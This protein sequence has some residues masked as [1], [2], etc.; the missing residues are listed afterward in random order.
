MAKN[1]A[2]SPAEI[3]KWADA[4]TVYDGK[5]TGSFWKFIGTIILEVIL[6]LAFAAAGVVLACWNIVGK[7]GAWYEDIKNP[8]TIACIIGGGILVLIGVYVVMAINRKHFLNN[9]GKK[10]Q[11]WKGYVDGKFVIDTRVVEKAKAAKNVVDSYESKAG[12]IFYT[13]EYYNE[14][15]ANNNNMSKSAKK[16]A[17]AKMYKGTN[18]QKKTDCEEFFITATDEDCLNYFGMSYA[19][20]IKDQEQKFLGNGEE[21]GTYKVTLNIVDDNGNVEESIPAD[22]WGNTF[23]GSWKEFKV[24]KALKAEEEQPAKGKKGKKK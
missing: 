24:E 11:E 6:F 4:K 2:Q 3:K 17:A 5:W 16:K 21:F 15:V 7:G 10:V 1:Y 23:G 14:Y 8:V 19:E 22:A 20:W 13:E 12:E 9:Q 18:K